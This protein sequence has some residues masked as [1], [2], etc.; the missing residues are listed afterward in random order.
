[1]LFVAMDGCEVGTFQFLF[2]IDVVIFLGFGFVCCVV[3]S[4]IMIL[5]KNGFCF[6]NG[7]LERTLIK[8]F[9]R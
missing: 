1:M 5:C 4:G 6:C 8:K 2:A 3:V 9:T 7:F